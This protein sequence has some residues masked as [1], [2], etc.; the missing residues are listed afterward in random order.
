[1]NEH[2]DI[3]EMRAGVASEVVGEVAQRYGLHD[4][5][6][7]PDGYVNFVA[8]KEG[9]LVIKAPQPEGEGGHIRLRQLAAEITN[10]QHLEAARAGLAPTQV[11]EL[12]EY[13]L[14][15]AYLVATYVP[16]RASMPAAEIAGLSASERETL[17]REYGAYITRQAEIAPIGT[18]AGE[19]LWAPAF[20]E[21][22][23]FS[24]R[25]YPTLTRKAADLYERWQT[26]RTA[27]HSGSIALRFIHGDLRLENS[28]LSDTYNLQGVFDFATAGR[29]DIAEELSRLANIDSTVLNGCLA[30]LALS[31]LDP[32]P[33]HV[34]IWQEMKDLQ[35]L[36]GW[37][38]LGNTRHDNYLGKREI[39]AKRYPQE[40]WGEL[41]QT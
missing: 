34:R 28:T 16:G 2:I 6:T 33:E 36:T 3:T 38:Q 7:I 22:G 39:V 31:G 41:W 14:D 24:E 15:P 40:N 27:V 1:M 26:Y 11:P 17:G 29:G 12:V 21:L 10:L 35:V 37:I 13:S 30:E 32:D 18:S 9:R 5:Q 8:F 4:A 23:E 19:S 25:S 20:G